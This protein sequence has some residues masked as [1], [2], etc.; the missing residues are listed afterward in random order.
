MISP[1]EIGWAYP[2]HW[3][4]LLAAVYLPVGVSLNTIPGLSTLT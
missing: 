4:L 1:G 3:Y 2:I